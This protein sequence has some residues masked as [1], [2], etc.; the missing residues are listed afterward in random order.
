MSTTGRLPRQD[1][2][3][4]TAACA[5]ESKS[6][7]AC[8]LLRYMSTRHLLA[9]DLPIMCWQRTISGAYGFQALAKHAEMAALIL[10]YLHALESRLEQRVT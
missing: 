6:K 7:A 3:M 10:S 8:V 4:S 5:A 9:Q 1:P 2:S